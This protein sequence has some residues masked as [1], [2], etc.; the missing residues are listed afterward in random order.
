MSSRW[1]DDIQTKI[2]TIV[3]TKTISKLK[4]KYPDLNFTMDSSSITEP[5]FPTVYITFLAPS[6]RGQDLIGQDVNAVNLT[7]QIDVLVNK[8]QGLTG[9]RDVA[10]EVEDNFKELRFSGTMPTFENN[11]TDVKRMIMRMSRI[12][13]YNDFL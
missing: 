10:Y 4:T 1:V 11:T 8:A 13:G 6:E 5:K 12:V 2:F 9:A 3:K 7:V